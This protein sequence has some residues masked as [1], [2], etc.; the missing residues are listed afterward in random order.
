MKITFSKNIVIGL[1]IL[2]VGIL[3]FFLLQKPESELVKVKV[4][5]VMDVE[6]PQKV[7][8]F[9]PA[10]LPTPKKVK[11]KPK[12]VKQIK[13]LPEKE[14][15]SILE[16]LTAVRTY[17]ETYTSDDAEV[18][19]TSEVQGYLLK[20]TPK[21]TV[22]KDTIKVNET[23]TTEIEVPKNIKFYLGP[24]I[25]GTTI[26]NMEGFNPVFGATAAMQ[27]RKDQILTLSVT[28]ERTVLAGLLFKL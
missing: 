9:P 27:N 28:T 1:L 21:V 2:T 14:E 7:Y 26:T 8:T 6:V 4:P 11:L 12:E 13:K 10:E 17:V 24:Q 19:V 18:E 16:L 25:G 5:V 15:D 22:F 3:V 20:Q 23:I